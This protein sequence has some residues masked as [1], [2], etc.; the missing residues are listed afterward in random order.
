M[1]DVNSLGESG[2][3]LIEL[4]QNES[5]L[6]SLEVSSLFILGAR[7]KL[8]TFQDIN[9]EIEQKEIEAWHKLI[10]ILTHEIMNSITPISSLTETMGSMLEDGDGNQKKKED[11]NDDTLADLRFS[12]STIQ[13][14]SE[15]LIQFVDSYRKF[16][17]VP[18]P[19]LSR[20]LISELLHSVSQLMQRDLKE[21]NIN[22]HVAISDQSLQVM[23][24]ETL[25]E[26]VLINLVTNAI[27][28]LENRPDPLITL[29]A[30]TFEKQTI[31]EVSDNG[32]GISKKDLPSIF[33]PFFSTKQE[34]SGI[35]LSLSKQIMNSHR[36]SIKVKSVLNEGTRF[37]LTF[38]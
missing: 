38:N 8:I 35:G 3:K 27:H 28:A 32:K 22:L 34:G 6:L 33:I 9:S 4:K 13:K 21:N 7:Y 26:Q 12:V 36:G 19:T 30:Y 18:K 20:V 17:R 29:S 37:M 5:T 2:R 14:R 31:L 25:V 1:E 10:R 15:G 23:M 11:I 24:D 16:S